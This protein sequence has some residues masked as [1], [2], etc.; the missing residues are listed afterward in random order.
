MKTSHCR[1]RVP[2]EAVNPTTSYNNRNNSK[3][4][5]K[6]NKKGSN[7]GGKYKTREREKNERIIRWWNCGEEG[8]IVRFCKR[9]PGN[10][11]S[12][13][14]RRPPNGTRIFRFT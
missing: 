7:D 5:N 14:V 13:F 1:R 4:R 3:R 12:P 8:H 11:R 2:I 9:T 6:N 10:G